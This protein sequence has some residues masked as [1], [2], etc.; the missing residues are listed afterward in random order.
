MVDNRR[1]KSKVVNSF[2]GSESETKTQTSL[3]MDTFQKTL[4]SLS[5]FSV[6]LF[7]NDKRQQRRIAIGRDREHKHQSDSK[8]SVENVLR[9]KKSN[10]IHGQ[11]QRTVNHFAEIWYKNGNKT[12]HH[13]NCWPP[14]QTK[15]VLCT[16]A[17]FYFKGLKLRK[18]LKIK[19]KETTPTYTHT[20][21]EDLRERKNNPK[22]KNGEQEGWLE[23]NVNYYLMRLHWTHLCCMDSFN[24]ICVKLKRF[25]GRSLSFQ[26]LKGI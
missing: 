17:A 8:Y 4:Q 14:L 5:G 6:C 7:A 15:A 12:F 16:F 1:L 26:L 2:L 19:A 22:A 3:S 9:C 20:H 24:I 21:R 18:Y 13:L 25:K 10:Y 11:V 23:W